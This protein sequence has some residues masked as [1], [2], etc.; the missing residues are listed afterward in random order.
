MPF[1][2]SEIVSQSCLL[3]WPCAQVLEELPKPLAL[4]VLQATPASLHQC[5]LHLP[6]SH[7]E[8]ALLARFPSILSDNTL[9]LCG[10]ESAKAES[11]TTCKTSQDTI[12]TALSAS[13]AFP[14]LSQ[15]RLSGMCMSPGR[16]GALCSALTK[17][18]AVTALL[19]SNCLLESS[20]IT[21]L[22]NPTTCE[23]IKRFSVSSCLLKNPSS[24]AEAIARSVRRMHALEHL[25]FSK[26][27]FRAGDACEVMCGVAQL[28]ILGD[29]RSLRIPVL[30]SISCAVTSFWPCLACCSQ[31][32]HLALTDAALS[33]DTVWGASVFLGTL[34][35][36]EALEMRVR[37]ASCL[38]FILLA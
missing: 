11:S 16:V 34:T 1:R 32:T 3:I 13:A 19:F 30:N 15:L 38:A 27:P 36:L 21:H 10:Q 8:D 35:K 18:T 2:P 9:V 22:L 6:S 5:L 37:R 7:H 24:V 26:L 17:L 14:Q 29:L 25:D 4:S 31:L 20:H 23:S 12:C 33:D 28:A